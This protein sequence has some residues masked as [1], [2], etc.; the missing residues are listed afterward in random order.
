MQA[1]NLV[2]LAK[3]NQ[4]EHQPTWSN[5]HSETT[6]DYIWMNANLANKTTTFQIEPTD[7]Y[8]ATDHQQLHST[9]DMSTLQTPS[10][11]C[12]K[13]KSRKIFNITKTNKEEWQDWRTAITLNIEESDLN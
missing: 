6:I 2:N 4:L 5:G 10:E 13:R 7:E 3:L 1:W 11:I 9:I 12:N 8:F